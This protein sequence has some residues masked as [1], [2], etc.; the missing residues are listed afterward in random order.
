MRNHIGDN[1]FFDFFMTT[2]IGQKRALKKIYLDTG[3]RK[4]DIV[5]VHSKLFSFG[6]LTGSREDSVKLFLEPLL[7]IVGSQGTIVAPTY[8]SGYSSYGDAYIH[9]KTPSDVGML[10]NYIRKM[11]GAVRSFHPLASCAAIGDKKNEICKNV[12]RSAFGWGSVFNKL[13]LLKGKCLYLGMKLGESCTFLHYVEQ[14]YGVSHCYNKAFFHPAYKNNIPRQGP[15]LAFLR[16]RESAY[17]D[18]SRF[19]KHMRK[20][21]KI[22]ERQ[23]SGAP[24]QL[25]NFDDCFTE[26]MKVLDKD[27]CYFIK[28]PFYIT[29]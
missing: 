27:P 6:A 7:E 10:T 16:N 29:K 4:G 19:E 22:K 3:I 8:T 26:G 21:R 17:Y 5:F 24:I 11:H 1:M 23:F 28:Q 2:I 25:V 20:G 12:T 13:H 15:F 9:E 14:M 18:F